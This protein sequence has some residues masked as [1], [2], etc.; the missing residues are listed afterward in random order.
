MQKKNF[1][2]VKCFLEE[3][4]IQRGIKHARM[5]IQDVNKR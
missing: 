3:K 1:L 2:R 5:V 4:E